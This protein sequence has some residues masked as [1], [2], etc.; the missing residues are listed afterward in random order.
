M[1]VGTM[2]RPAQYH[3]LRSRV[4]DTKEARLRARHQHF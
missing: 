1:E 4:D 2:V 3:Q